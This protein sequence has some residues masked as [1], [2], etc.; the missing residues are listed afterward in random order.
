MRVALHFTRL[1]CNSGAYRVLIVCRRSHSLSSRLLPSV[2]RPGRDT[3]ET[4]LGPG[5]TRDLDSEKCS[6]QETHGVGES[7]SPKSKRYRAVSNAD[8]TGNRNRH[9]LKRCQHCGVQLS[10]TVRAQTASNSAIPHSC[11]LIP[12]VPNVTLLSILGG[13]TVE[14]YRHPHCVCAPHRLLP[15]LF[16]YK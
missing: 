10:I 3:A 5:S 6:R 9:S 13:T 8:V 4:I 15:R 14:R 12:P 2:T 11:W 7:G 1:N 16:S